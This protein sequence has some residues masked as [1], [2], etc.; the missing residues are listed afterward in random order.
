MVPELVRCKCFIYNFQGACQTTWQESDNFVDFLSNFCFEGEP[1]QE[2]VM[3][4]QTLSHAEHRGRLG[5]L[6][7]A[8]PIKRTT[9][10][11]ANFCFPHTLVL[12]LHFYSYSCNTG[13][14]GGPLCTGTK[15]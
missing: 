12:F 6:V 2:D 9:N 11:Y 15:I 4:S 14:V 13:G 8:K 7:R 1:L 10:N 3:S 5:S